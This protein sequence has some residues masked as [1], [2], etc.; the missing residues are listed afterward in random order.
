MLKGS[1]GNHGK[2][3]FIVRCREDIQKVKA[4]E[5]DA[6]RGTGPRATSQGRFRWSA[7]NAQGR[8]SG[9]HSY[10]S[11]EC[12][13]TVVGSYRGSSL[14]VTATLCESKISRASGL[15]AAAR[16]DRLMLP[17]LIQ[18][19]PELNDE[20]LLQELIPGTTEYSVSL[21]VNDGALVDVIETK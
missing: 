14:R 2:N 4:T 9:G 7:R 18:V 11:V 21:L 16:S 19:T 1:E 12:A 10:T 3:V 15:D 5:P 20:W 13:D 6:H 17:A 8:P